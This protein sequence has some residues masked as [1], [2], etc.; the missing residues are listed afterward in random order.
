MD[1]LFHVFTKG[2]GG[3]LIVFALLAF[4]ISDSFVNFIIW[5]TGYEY[6]TFW[7]LGF[8]MIITAIICKNF[9]L[10]F[11][12]GLAIKHFNKDT[13]KES[14]KKEK[15][16]FIFIDLKYWVYILLIAG[17]ISL[18]YAFVGYIIMAKN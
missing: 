17:F 1:I 5:Y 6:E 8:T 12:N 10:L 3:L 7:Y 18:V 2:Y 15:N 13:K 9:I 11:P 16:T 4:Q 14:I